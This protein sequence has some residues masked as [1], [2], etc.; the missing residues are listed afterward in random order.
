MTH[1]SR[2]Q[3]LL[4]QLDRTHAALRNAV[5]RVPADRRAERTSPDR[6][7]VA[8]VLEHLAIVETRVASLF[9][10]LV[11]AA[12]SGTSVSERAHEERV[13]MKVLQDR[14][15]KVPAP[16]V[17]HPSKGWDAT[18]AWDAA[19]QARA[20]FRAQVEAAAA[21]DLSNATRRHPF[22]GV[23]NGYQWIES[24]SGHEARHAAQIEE[25]AGEWGY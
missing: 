14:S 15:F 4:G 22:L 11:E 20:V 5:D 16:D 12:A 23:L 18:A 13:D 2:I 21:H 9:G 25:I 7:S 6:W 17:L 3:T 10:A 8:E 24:V 19:E 1:E